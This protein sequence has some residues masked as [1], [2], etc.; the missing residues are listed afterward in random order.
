MEKEEDDDDEI[1]PV[2]E[3]KSQLFLKRALL[4]FVDQIEDFHINHRVG[5][6]LLFGEKQIYF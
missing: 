3:K 2:I 5:V 6:V 4:Y 1:C